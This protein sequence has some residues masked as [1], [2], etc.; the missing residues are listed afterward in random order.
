MPAASFIEGRRG[1]LRQ[2][3]AP[4]P[5]DTQLGIRRSTLA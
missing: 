5:R 1:E 3:A 2:K 4:H